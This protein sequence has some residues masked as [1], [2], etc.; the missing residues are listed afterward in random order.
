MKWPIPTH[1]LL[2]AQ[3]LPTCCSLIKLTHCTFERALIDPRYTRIELQEGESKDRFDRGTET[4]LV[5]RA[6]QAVKLHRARIVVRVSNKNIYHE[7]CGT[8]AFDT[9]KAKDLSCGLRN[10]PTGR[11]MHTWSGHMWWA[12]VRVSGSPAT[13]AQPWGPRAHHVTPHNSSP[14]LLARTSIRMSIV[15]PPKTR[16]ILSTFYFVYYSISKLFSFFI[17][18]FIFN[19]LFYL[20]NKN[21]HRFYYD[22]F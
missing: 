9:G 3:R 20:K 8:T 6:R 14:V 4:K 1:R 12:H 10:R 22:L 7:I 5:H 17:L 18:L 19:H 13:S 15:F 11:C 21:Y 16:K 2:R